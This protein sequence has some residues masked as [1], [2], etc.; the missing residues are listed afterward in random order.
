LG[1]RCR[2]QRLRD[3]KLQILLDIL[4]DRPAVGSSGIV[5]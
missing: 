2:C 3:K 4:A 5:P 1:P